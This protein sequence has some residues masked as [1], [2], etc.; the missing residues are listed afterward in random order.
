MDRAQEPVK[1]E[2]I[3]ANKNLY[4][5]PFKEASIPAL[6]TQVI[7]PEDADL[8]TQKTLVRLRGGEESRKDIGIDTDIKLDII[9]VGSC[10]VSR[11][12]YRIGKGN[13]YV[14]LDFGLLTHLGV[15]TDKTL[16][17]TT[18]HEVQVCSTR[19]ESVGSTTRRGMIWVDD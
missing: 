18:V 7:C 13:G 10:A 16:V 19:L 2:V 1:L 4:V 17:V 8:N 12:G 6:F 14:D 11:Q 3:K 9:V 5:P 15:I